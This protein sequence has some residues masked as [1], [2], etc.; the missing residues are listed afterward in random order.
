LFKL[1][2]AVA[3][4]VPLMN[5]AKEAQ[6]DLKFELIADHEIIRLQTGFVLCHNIANQPEFMELYDTKKISWW[7]RL[8]NK[9]EN[10]FTYTTY[11]DKE[12]F[13][14]A[15]EIDNKDG[16]QIKILMEIKDKLTNSSKFQGKPKL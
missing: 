16:E 10:F 6:I 8:R 12:I 2:L 9:I 4:I 13:E 14:S 11:I 5:R 1:G 7:K 15:Y 3:E